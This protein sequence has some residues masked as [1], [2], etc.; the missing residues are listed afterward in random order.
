[1]ERQIQ[2]IADIKE[3]YQ[4]YFIDV[5]SVLYNEGEGVIASA[6]EGLRV[7]QE[8][9]KTVVLVSNA[10]RSGQELSTFLAREGLHSSLYQHAVTSGDCMRAYFV[11]RDK[12]IRCYLSGRSYSRATFEGVPVT[13]V[14]TPEEAEI[15]IPCVPDHDSSTLDPFIPLLD[16][17]LAAHLPMLC[18]NPDEYILIK[19]RRV[20]RTGLF[21]RYYAEKG[22]EVI[23]FGK[24]HT[25]IYT[26]AHALIPHIPK[27]RILMI[28]DGLK[29]DILGAQNFGIDS[30]WIT[31]GVSSQDRET[32]LIPT[33]EM[34]I[35]G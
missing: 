26:H 33:Y 5:W 11:K 30:L 35:F 22:G 20:V 10:A 32:G 27:E 16:R 15:F 17:C 28:G 2:C 29:T 19:G 25:F 8:S 34:A 6:K 4:G 3:K 23:A 14:A 7:L 12:P 13:F 18:G 9:E 31:S 21:A 1:M 24:P